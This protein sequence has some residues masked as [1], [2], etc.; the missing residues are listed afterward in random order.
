MSGRAWSDCPETCGILS[1]SDLDLTLLAASPNH[2][3]SR[4]TSPDS[5]FSLHQPGVRE[6]QLSTITPAGPPAELLVKSLLPLGVPSPR[7]VLIHEKG[8]QPIQVATM[9]PRG[10]HRVLVA[11]KSKE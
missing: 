1:I 6:A 10:I 11:Q 3:S 8:T 2:F 5:V 4:R 7:H 9:L